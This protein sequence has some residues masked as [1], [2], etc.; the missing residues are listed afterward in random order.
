[1]SPTDPKDP[2][3]RPFR[4]A[5]W[6]VY[7]VVAVGFSALIIFSVFKS[8][9]AMTPDRPTPAGQAL[10]AADCLVKAR[11]LLDRLEAQRQA[12]A[13]GDA[14]KADRRF[15]EFR[16]NWLTEKRVVEA[17][18]ALDDPGREKLAAVFADLERLLDHTTTSSVQFSGAVAPTLE[19]VRRGLDEAARP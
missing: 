10:P 8:V 19:A 4:G 16:T 11:G 14:T 6:A 3:F 18:C 7:L 12:F 13:E 1:M 15:L 17:Q 5:A 9:I 2:R